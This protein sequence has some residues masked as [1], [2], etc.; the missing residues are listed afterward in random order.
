VEKGEEFT[1]T[2]GRKPARRKREGEV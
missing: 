2:E 1:V